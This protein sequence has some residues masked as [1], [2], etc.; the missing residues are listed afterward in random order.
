MLLVQY[1]IPISVTFLNCRI[2]IV[3]INAGSSRTLVCQHKFYP[4]L[5][6]LFQGSCFI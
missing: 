4:E 2:G 6:I 3:D 5:A 1:D